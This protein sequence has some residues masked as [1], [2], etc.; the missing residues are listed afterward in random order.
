M[1]PADRIEGGSSTDVGLEQDPA[2]AAGAAG[3]VTGEPVMKAEFQPLPDSAG[4]GEA[5]SIDILMDVSL[6]VTVE[7][8]KATVTVRQVLDMGQG[9][10]IEL[11]RVAGDPVEVFVSGK[12]LGK[13]EIVVVNDRFGVRMTEILSG[14][15]G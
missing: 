9:S 1:N 15:R 14:V 5:A 13:G 6:P 11:D 12:I 4:K 10:V 7:L 2:G 8:G 3:A